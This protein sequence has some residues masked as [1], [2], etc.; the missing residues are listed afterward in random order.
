MAENVCTSIIEH[1]SGLPDP[2]I[3][4]KTQHSLVDIVTTALCAVLS[5]ADDWVRDRRL[6]QSQG[7]LVQGLSETGGRHPFS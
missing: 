2:R 7:E 3:L 4:L 1:F 5:G 6:C